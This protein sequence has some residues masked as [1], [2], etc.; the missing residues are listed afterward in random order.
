MSFSRILEIVGQVLTRINGWISRPVYL[1]INIQTH[2]SRERNPNFIADTCNTQ[3]APFTDKNIKKF[4]ALYFLHRIVGMAWSCLL[5]NMKEWATKIQ[6]QN[7]NSYMEFR[8]IACKGIERQDHW[9]SIYLTCSR[10]KHPFLNRSYLDSKWHI[11]YARFFSPFLTY[12][13]APSWICPNNVVLI[14]REIIGN[15]AIRQVFNSAKG[16]K[17]KQ[18]RIFPCIQYR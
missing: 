4:T 8:N 7:K 15:I 3:K 2:S 12:S 16:A 9:C 11:L 6:Q 14:K 1:Y 13:F 5:K 10:N 17:I 18:G